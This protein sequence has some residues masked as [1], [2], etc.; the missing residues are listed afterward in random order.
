[1]AESE[2]FH[3]NIV[4][5]FL[6]TTYYSPNHYLNTKGRNDLVIYNGKEVKSPVGVIIEAKSPTNKAEFP[7]VNQLNSKALQEVVLYYL[8]ERVT[9]KT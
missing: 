6:D 9:H 8:R 2:E 7:K 5:K 1:M 4:S 3:E